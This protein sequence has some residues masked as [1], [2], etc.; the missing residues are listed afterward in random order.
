MHFA[1]VNHFTQ[2]DTRSCEAGLGWTAGA[3]PMP[4]ETGAQV[5]DL[6]KRGSVIRREE[7]IA[8]HQWT[9]RGYIFCRAAI[10][11]SACQFCGAKSWDDAAEEIIEAAVRKEYDKLR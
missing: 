5:C 10:P 9:D 8:F 3:E 7:E 1:N 2:L 6:C 4:S 11:M